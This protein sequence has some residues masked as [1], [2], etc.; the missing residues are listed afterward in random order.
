[1]IYETITALVET[2]D[3]FHHWRVGFDCHAIATSLDT[4]TVRT[5]DGLTCYPMNRVYWWYRE[6]EADYEPRT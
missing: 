2:E 4:L 1:M 6:E 3:G 5:E